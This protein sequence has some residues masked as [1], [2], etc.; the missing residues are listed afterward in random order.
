MCHSAGVSKSFVTCIRYDGV[1]VHDMYCD[2]QTRPEPVHD[3]CIGR[4]CQP[5]YSPA[6][7]C[8]GGL[9]AARRLTLRRPTSFRWEAS[10]WSECSRTCG[11]GFQFRQV[12]CWKMLSPGLDS[13][14]YSD[15]C[16]MADLERPMERRPC[17]SPACGPQWEVAEWTV[18]RDTTLCSSYS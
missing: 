5:R 12:R 15:L 8:F 2:A 1:E 16:T 4:E 9:A 7:K 11:E 18:V 17:K 13:S 3:F 10:S 14:V 6:E